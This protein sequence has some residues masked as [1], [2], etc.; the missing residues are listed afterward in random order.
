MNPHLKIRSLVVAG[1]AG[2]SVALSA[3][4]APPHT[5][6][7]VAMDLP[8]AMA[9][10]SG[11]PPV[12]GRAPSM[13]PAPL[14]RELDAEAV[15]G[16]TAPTIID[17][18]T[19]A[20]QIDRRPFR[21][22]GR[23]PATLLPKHRKPA[24]PAVEGDN[25]LRFRHA[26]DVARATP[27]AAFPGISQTPWSPPDPSIA[28]G[29]NH[30]LATVNMKIAWYDK[31]GN[32][33][34]E[35][36]LDSTGSPGFFEEI[37]GGSFTFDP[38]C[39]YDPHVGR[40]V[41][42]ALEYYASSNEAWMT[43][44]VSDD[45]DPNGIWFKYRTWALV[46]SQGSD[47][48]VDYPGLGFDER[49]WYI[50]SNLFE[51]G[52]GPGPGF[53]GGLLRVIDKTGPLSGGTA[54]WADVLA[55]G[56]SWQVTQAL[57]AGDEARIVRQWNADTLELAHI[58]NA[59]AAPSLSSSLVAVPRV[60]GDGAAATPVGA[61]L[62]IV[63][64]RL[65]NATIRDGIVWCTNHGSVASSP[66]EIASGVWYAVDCRGATPTLQQA[67]SFTFG[68]DEESFFPAVAV[69]G[70]GQVGLI[71]GRSGPDRHPTLEVAGRL[72]SDPLNTMSAG[73]EIGSS[74]TSPPGMDG[75]NRWGDYFDATVD[76]ADDRTFWVVGEL[77][78][79]G[80]WV[81][82]IARFT[83]G[84]AADL[85]GDGVVNGADFGILLAAWGD[86]GGSADLNH[87]GT[88]NGADIGLL[89]GEWSE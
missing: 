32:A 87:D 16:T 1:L 31:D 60:D 74:I 39:F 70:A 15:S 11:E 63:D 49:G 61:G 71:Y 13:L 8:A 37:G 51:L 26:R 27:G 56:A 34:F 73:V 81:T 36:F 10:I 89:L 58:E 64:P 40:F 23:R 20:T 38:K 21:G 41:V 50:T 5:S 66:G 67:G 19:F 30:V 12:S 45:D 25:G 22:D 48:W 4:H 33:Q 44:A 46:S 18:R 9:P 42:L 78:T 83:I 47:Y 57:A 86:S 17:T 3:C 6:D 55:G 69:N 7:A 52:N 76:P 24:A 62:W 54:N 2:A 82:E 53:L 79:E 14:A 59:P 88:V 72:P 43:F 84:Q 35:Q 77:Q 65:M 85:N 75:L 80:G 28:V 68:G 29:P